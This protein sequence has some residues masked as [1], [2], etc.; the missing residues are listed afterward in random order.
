MKAATITHAYP[1]HLLVPKQRQALALKVI[2]NKAPISD[3]ARQSQVSRKILYVQKNKALLLK[4][5]FKKHLH[6]FYLHYAAKLNNEIINVFCA[7]IF[8]LAIPRT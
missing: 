1:A 7:C 4:N 3:I 5:Y 6:F 2:Q 8:P